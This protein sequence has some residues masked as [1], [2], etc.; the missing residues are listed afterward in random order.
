MVEKYI[1]YYIDKEVEVKSL[2]EN[3]EFKKSIELSQ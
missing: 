2:M 3:Y 1:K